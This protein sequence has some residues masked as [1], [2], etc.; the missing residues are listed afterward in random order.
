MNRETMR[1]LVKTEPTVGYEYKTNWPVR[2]PGECATVKY[3]ADNVAVNDF[4]KETMN[5]WFKW[6]MFQSVEQIFR[7]G[8]GTK[9]LKKC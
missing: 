9:W 5:V 6:N 3:F 1:A 7:S 8:N 4:P 2:Q